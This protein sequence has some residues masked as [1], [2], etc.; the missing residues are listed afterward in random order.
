MNDLSS[1][2]EKIK[3]AKPLEF[4]NIFD[5]SIELFKKSWLYCFLLQLFILVVTLPFVFVVYVPFVMSIVANSQKGQVPDGIQTLFQGMSLFYLVV[6]ILGILA[7][8]VFQTALNAAFFRILNN[9]EEGHEAKVSDLF[10]FLKGKYFG[11]VSLLT[12]AIIL[13]SL[14]AALLCYLPLIY[15]IIPLS[16]T[17]IVFAFN[18]DMSV[19]EVVKISFNLGTKKWLIS[20]GLF[21]VANL[22]VVILSLLTCGIG[23]LFLSSFIYI[24][25]YIIYMEVL[26]NKDVDMVDVSE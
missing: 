12:F 22:M 8:A 25:L 24:P 4:G 5:R 6:F 23:T 9:I 19:G 13:I 17:T 21:F 16:F 18:S 14:T 10:Y 7:A 11:K 20:F 1:K 26:G 3:Q 2:L 15:A